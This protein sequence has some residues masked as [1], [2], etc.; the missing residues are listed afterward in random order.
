MTLIRSQLIS[1][2]HS[3]Y[4]LVG[5]IQATLNW[6]SS[7]FKA[8]FSRDKP[9]Q[10]DEII[11]YCKLGMRSEKAAIAATQLGYSKYFFCLD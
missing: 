11:F 1:I 4:Q 5:D 10:A 8:K 6:S 9:Q 2:T 7:Q 3:F